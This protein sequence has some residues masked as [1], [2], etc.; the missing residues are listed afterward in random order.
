VIV[1]KIQSTHRM[2]NLSPANLRKV[3][4]RANVYRLYFPST[5]TD[6]VTYTCD[7]LLVFIFSAARLHFNHITLAL[8]IN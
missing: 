1:K 2:V 7:W 8:C 6:H 3:A 4:M 5:E